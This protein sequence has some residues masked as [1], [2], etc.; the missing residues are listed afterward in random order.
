MG[1]FG[2]PSRDCVAL[3]ERYR[4]LDLRGEAVLGEHGRRPGADR[5]LADE[6]V[7]GAGVAEHPPG[8][9]DVQDHRQGA[10][11][12]G[13][14]DDPHRNVAVGAAG[15][16]DPLVGDLRRGRRTGLGLVDDLSALLGA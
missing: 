11:G 13:R 2:Q 15:H 12:S 9:M 6:T 7:M 1:A 3:L 8:S 10:R 5:Y 14:A 16:V 4:V